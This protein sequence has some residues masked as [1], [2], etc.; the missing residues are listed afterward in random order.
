M[1]NKS[2]LL[3]IYKNKYF[4]LPSYLINQKAQAISTIIFT[5]LAL[6][7]F[8]I[9]AI[10]PTISTII[11]LK[12]QLSDNKNV[13]MQLKQKIENLAA[14]QTQYNTL[15]PDIPLIVENIPTTPAV[16]LLIAQIQALAVKNNITL[17]T[18]QSLE[19]DLTKT[20]DNLKVP[21][22][23]KFT[24]SAS[25]NYVN[26]TAFLSSLV[27]FNRLISIDG[28]SLSQENAGI[29]KLTVLG[30]AYMKK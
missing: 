30:E 3:R 24:L 12:K 11:Q 23:F 15:K 22:S 29:T 14:L 16:P 4:T 17:N 7:F 25:G 5:F 10:S 2:R 26:V 28:V 20:S 1:N 18:L 27:D 8:G 19:V 13:D 9:F 6:S 21:S